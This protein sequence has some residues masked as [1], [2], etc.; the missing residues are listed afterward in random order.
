MS[1][2]GFPERVLF[3]TFTEKQTSHLWVLHSP[4]KSLMVKILMM[5]SCSDT[6][7]ISLSLLNPS[8]HHASYCS[9]RLLSC[10]HYFFH[11]S[12]HIY[13]FFSHFLPSLLH[14]CLP[15]PSSALCS[16]SPHPFLHSS[17]PTLLP[18][19]LSRP[20]LFQKPGYHG[21]HITSAHTSQQSQKQNNTERG[22]M[23]VEGD[24][25]GGGIKK[26][27]KC[28]FKVNVASFVVVGTCLILEA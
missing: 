10:S 9:T 27:R 28:L 20:N 7:L 17:T 8:I 13:L 23:G 15:L 12:V 21:E 3:V 25:Q 22:K 4:F 18:P 24:R 26:R 1:S 6:S 2:S 11:P 19:I 14:L 5:L 16:P